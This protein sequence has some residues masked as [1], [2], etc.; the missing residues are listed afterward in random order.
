MD[1]RIVQLQHFL[2]SVFR[3]FRVVKYPFPRVKPIPHHHTINLQGDGTDEV[4]MYSTHLSVDYSSRLKYELTPATL[5]ITR[6]QRYRSRLSSSFSIFV[7]FF[8]CIACLLN[9]VLQSPKL[10]IKSKAWHQAQ[11]L[12]S[13]P[14]LDIKSKAL[15]QV[16]APK[17]GIKYLASSHTPRKLAK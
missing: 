14:R 17:L 13:S 1:C 2:I 3:C 7:V 10:G 6:R 15:H 11:S 8:V 4:K 5:Q 16:K 12:A 9:V